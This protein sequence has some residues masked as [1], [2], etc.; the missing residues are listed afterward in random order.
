[1]QTRSHVERATILFTPTSTEPIKCNF[2]CFSRKGKSTSWTLTSLNNEDA[3]IFSLKTIFQ[4]LSGSELKLRIKFQIFGKYSFTTF[5]KDSTSSTIL[6][7]EQAKS[8]QRHRKVA[9]SLLESGD[10]ADVTFE[11]KDDQRIAA[12][13][14]ILSM[15]SNVFAA[16]FATEMKEKTEGV[17]KLDDMGGDGLKVFLK[18]VY[19]GE[20][21]EKWNEFYDEVVYAANKVCTNDK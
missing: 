16:M 13:K 18:F 4:K 5:G 12:H 7:R 2:I 17:V 3:K 10:R 8:L 9:L 14:F 11:T 21:D 15:Q 6:E 20:L 1:M 19:T